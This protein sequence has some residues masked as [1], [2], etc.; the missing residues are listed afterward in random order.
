M[1]PGVI[2]ASLLKSARARLTAALAP[3]TRRYRPLLVDADV[4]GWIDDTRAER[5][6]RF[7]D[8]FIVR[9]TAVAFDRC[10][11]DE[12]TRSSAINHVTV[13]LHREGALSAWRNERYDVGPALGAAPWFRLER[14]AAR[15]F[16]V[17]TWAAHV[18]GLTP[19]AGA[20]R[21]WLARRSHGKAIDPGKLDNLVGGGAASGLSVAETLIKE[22]WEEAGIPAPLASQAERREQ[23]E[24]RCEQ[25]NGLQ[26]ESVI[27][28]DLALPSDFSPVNQDGEVD[29]FRLMAFSEVAR[30]LNCAAGEDQMTLDAALVALACLDRIVAADSLRPSALRRR[31]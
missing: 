13:T 28:H 11:A 17:H 2:D 16:G 12:A 26:W 19:R 3:P 29:E 6:A 23:V 7:R 18:N 5:L 4:A 30:L 27:A 24:I 10:L 8:V 9:E 22:A 25:R 14:A 20:T 1:I 15:Y 21:M 31:T